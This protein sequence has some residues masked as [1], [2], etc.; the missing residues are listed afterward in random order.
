MTI[1]EEKEE[2]IQELL[3]V[4]DDIAEQGIESQREYDRRVVEQMVFM[5]EGQKRE[6]EMLEYFGE[7]GEEI[8][9]FYDDVLRKAIRRFYEEKQEIWAKSLPSSLSL[10]EMVDY[11]KSRCSWEDARQIVGMLN[12]L[13]RPRASKEDAALIDSIE[14]DYRR[15]INGHPQIEVNVNTSGNY[16]GKTIHYYNRENEDGEQE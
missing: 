4:A 2:V 7:R 14:E 16:V 1:E 9:A 6:P 10:S 12:Y 13:Y 5:A 15:R 8:S 3:L 11:C